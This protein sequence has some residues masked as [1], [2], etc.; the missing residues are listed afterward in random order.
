M[1][2]NKLKIGSK[3]PYNINIIIEIPM[4]SGPIKYE[5]DSH[6]ETMKVDRFIG[7]HIQYPINYGFIPCTLSGD[8]D[9][10]D[11]L[12]YSQHIIATQSM[13][14]VKPIGMLQT[15]DE[16][17]QDDKILCVPINTIDEQYK[18]ITDYHELPNNVL[19]NIEHFFYRYK[20]LEKN[21]WVNIIGWKNKN[22]AHHTIKIAYEKYILN[23]D[24]K[25]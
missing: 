18:Y 16:K 15:K 7:T 23:F 17:G 22:L 11:A 4:L 14:T 25:K 13:I 3:A 9:T 21:K 19:H 2:Y 5:F 1:N 24:T 20:E 10:L 12:V 6:L 8:G